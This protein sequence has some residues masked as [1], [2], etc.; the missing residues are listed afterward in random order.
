MMTGTRFPKRLL[1]ALALC[2]AYIVVGK[3]SLRLA[4]VHPSASPVWPP[5]GIAIVALLTLGRRYWPAILVGAFF[6]N[7]TTTG[8]ALTSLGVAA[9]NTL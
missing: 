7:L 4:S 6:V 2:V 5:T 8:T 3:L 9:G 1:M